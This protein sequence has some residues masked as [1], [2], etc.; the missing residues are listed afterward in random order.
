MSD[1]GH[2]LQVYGINGDVLTYFVFLNRKNFF[3]LKS[4]HTGKRGQGVWSSVF[5]AASIS[6]NKSVATK[7]STDDVA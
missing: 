1:D 4:P 3:S 7:V 5:N 2:G 6:Q